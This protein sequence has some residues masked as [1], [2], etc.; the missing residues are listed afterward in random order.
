MISGSV[1]KTFSLA[2]LKRLAVVTV[3]KS[4]RLSGLVHRG[5]A[6]REGGGERGGNLGLGPVSGFVVEWNVDL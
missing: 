1:H 4:T 6:E 2:N 5:V 3:K